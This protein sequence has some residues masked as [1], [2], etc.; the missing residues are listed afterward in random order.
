MSYKDRLINGF[1]VF[2]HML[3]RQKVQA[4]LVIAGG[5]AGDLAVTGILKGDDVVGILKLPAIEQV[6]VAGAAAGDIT[7]TGITTDDRLV[8]VIDIVGTDLTSEFSITAANTINNAPGGTSSASS[9]LIVTYEKAP[10][11][12]A[13]EFSVVS[14]GVVN[15]AGGTASTGFKVLVTWTQWAER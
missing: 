12:L 9:F 3:R 10:E 5:A 6:S 14:D 1:P 13:S 11:D 8:S 15:N 4:Q 2:S 7:V